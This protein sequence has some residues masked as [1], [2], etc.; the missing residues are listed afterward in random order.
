MGRRIDL[1][2]GRINLLFLLFFVVFFV[3]FLTW[4]FGVLGNNN[5]DMKEILQ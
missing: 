4:Y 5:Q 3:T 2:R 1:I